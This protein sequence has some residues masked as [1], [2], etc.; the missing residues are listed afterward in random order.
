[1]RK[2]LAPVL[3]LWLFFGGLILGLELF[4]PFNWDEGW[5]VTVARNWVE[6]G[7][8][9]MYM[10]GEPTAPGLSAAFP[11]VFS[12]AAAFQWFGIGLWQARFVSVLYM[13][14]ALAALFG[15]ARRLYG[16]RVG[17]VALLALIPFASMAHMQT[18]YIGRNVLAEPIM[19]FLLLAGY[20]F[21]LSALREN[22]KLRE[23]VA[24][25]GAVLLWSLALDSKAQPLP[26]WSVSLLCGL[27]YCILQRRW[28]EAGLTVIAFLA[29]LVLMRA[30]LLG[31]D[32]LLQGHTIPSIPVPGILSAT[33]FVLYPEARINAALRF[34]LTGLLLLFG[35]MGATQKWRRGSAPHSLPL[36]T[37]RLMLL[38]FVWSWMLWYLLLSNGVERYLFP[39]SFV[40]SIF[41][42][43]GIDRYVISFLR[44][45]SLPRTRRFNLR[46]V[47]MVL[48]S[49]IGVMY[50]I[51]TVWQLVPQV[52]RDPFARETTAWLNANLSR[53][54]VVE[55]YESEIL[56]GLETRAHY[57]PDT[58]SFEL[59]RKR[60]LDP[61]MP[62]SYGPHSVNADVIV[63]GPF[64]ER[65]HLYDEIL[66][67]D[68]YRLLVKVGHY[69]IYQNAMTTQSQ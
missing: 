48:A 59:S 46:F 2:F 47:V 18:L 22:N 24:L 9:G 64:D 40:G 6:R 66:A 32:L 58:I 1:M 62:L 30:W 5:T 20:L 55:T 44:R 49:F 26:F 13:M 16:G 56:F 67:N 50:L 29:S 65:F 45:E 11:S 54:A 53:E 4:P 60:D 41:V 27:G 15:L 8:Y 14:G 63:V 39:P 12:I 52:H 38:A 35:L 10:S 68:K 37:M 51:L 57:P 25:L 28:R 23:A 33:A 21:F 69:S 36:Q 42:G 61:A 34:L 3:L 19:L 43:L 31:A 17:L 7:F